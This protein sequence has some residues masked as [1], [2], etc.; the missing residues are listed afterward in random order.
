M[1]KRSLWPVYLGAMLSAAVW[2]APEEVCAG[3]EEMTEEGRSAEDGVE[4]VPPAAAAETAMREESE[5]AAVT[6][7]EAGEGEVKEAAEGKEAAVS[8]DDTDENASEPAPGSEPEP[9]LEPTPGPGP[10]PEPVTE[11]APEPG[12]TPEPEPAPESEPEPEP[13]PAP[14]SEPEPKPEPEPEHVSDSDSVSEPAPVSAEEPSQSDPPVSE[15]AP[16]AR[17]SAVPR[18]AA[19]TASPA[20]LAAAAAADHAAAMTTAA[21][22][23]QNARTYTTAKRDRTAEAASEEA[24]YFMIRRVSGL[25]SVNISGGILPVYESKADDARAAGYLAFGGSAVILEDVGD[26]WAYVESGDV[27]GFVRR[28]YLSDEKAAPY[29]REGVTAVPALPLSENEAFFYCPMTHRDA[30]E[31][32]RLCGTVL[33]EMAA[34]YIGSPYVWGGTSLTEGCDCSGF[35][36]RLYE[37]LGITLP[38]VSRQQALAGWEVPADEIRPGD[39]IFYETDGTVTHVLLASG[40]QLAVNA[41]GAASGIVMSEIET[42]RIAAVRRFILTEEEFEAVKAA[43]RQAEEAAQDAQAAADREAAYAAEAVH[44]ELIWAIVAQEDDTSYEGALGVITCAVNRAAQNY[45]GYGTTAY[46]QLT[47]PGQFCYSPEISDPSLWQSRLGG[48]VP[49]YV[50]AAVEDC[51]YRGIRNHDFLNFRS[52][53]GTSLRIQIGSN[54]YF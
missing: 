37:N 19:V 23:A 7:P 41:A 46:A 44:E 43:K 13:E 30:E 38:R 33:S 10:A 5:A 52:S 51:L 3:T 45:G 34:G 20:G 24:G 25:P 35:V 50:K 18:T 48:R 12:L 4:V 27:R 21:Q 2:T 9:E 53:R 40:S 17:P 29:Q 8:I 54:W 1:I 22:P 15:P 14:E 16:A 36:L 28:R 31:F 49:D 39:L 26:G 11:P 47:A 42:A 32:A 6:A